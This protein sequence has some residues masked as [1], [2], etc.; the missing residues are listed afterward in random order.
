M[1]CPQTENKLVGVKFLVH[2]LVNHIILRQRG[3]GLVKPKL[4]LSIYAFYSHTLTWL[5]RVTKRKAIGIRFNLHM[6]LRGP[7]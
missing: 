3:S 2:G 4:A 7:K 5:P 6:F 1:A